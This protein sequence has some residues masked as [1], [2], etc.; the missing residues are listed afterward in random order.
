MLT[1]TQALGSTA[2]VFIKEERERGD[3]FI[4]LW[5]LSKAYDTEDDDFSN[6]KNKSISFNPKFYY[7]PSEKTTFWFGLNG[8]T[9]IESVAI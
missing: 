6:I 8:L 4:R 5:T 7:Y 2:N 3:F 9:M 1:Q